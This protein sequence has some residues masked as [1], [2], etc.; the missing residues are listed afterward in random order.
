MSAIQKLCA[1]HYGFGKEDIQYIK[2]LGKTSRWV[3]IKRSYP[4][5]IISQFEVKIV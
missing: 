2:N 4:S 1:N 5:T 3:V